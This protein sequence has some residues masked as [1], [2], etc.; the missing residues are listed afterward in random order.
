MALDCPRCRKAIEF[1]GER[2][3]Y[4]PYCGVTLSTEQRAPDRTTTYLPADPNRTEAALG[5][6]PDDDVPDC[7]GGFRLVRLLGA[8][9]M[10]SVFEG[11]NPESGQRVA[12]KLLNTPVAASAAAIER[13][14]QEGRLASQITHPNCVFVLRADEDAG[15]PFIVMELMSGVTLRDL[16]KQRGPLPPSEAVAKILD[17]IDGLIE[18]HRLNILHRDVKPSNCFLVKDGRVKVG[19]FGLSKSLHADVNLTQTG[20]FLGTVLYAPPEQL[21]GEALDLSAD[22]YAVAATLYFLLTGRAPFES[23]SPTTVIARVLS[24]SPPDVGL[25]RPELPRR[26]ARAVMRGLERSPDKRWSTL[27]EFRAALAEFAGVVLRPARISTRAAAFAIDLVLLMPAWIATTLFESWTGTEA[28]LMLAT[29]AAYFLVSEWQFGCTVG[30]WLL[31][32]RVVDGE[33]GDATSFAKAAGRTGIFFGITAGLGAAAEYAASRFGRAS[34]DD[35]IVI[36][37]LIDVAGSALLTA[38]ARSRSGPLQD[39]FSGTRVVQRP[40][41]RTPRPIRPFHTANPDL[42]PLVECPELPSEVGGFQIRGVLESANGRFRV[43]GSEPKLGRDAVVWFYPHGDAVVTDARRSLARPARA[44]WL[45]GG[46]V[47]ELTWDAFLAPV[48]PALDQVVRPG[49]GLGW[50]AT[51]LMLEQLADEILRSRE[52]APLAGS[53]S[54]ARVHVRPDGQVQISDRLPGAEHPGEARDLRFLASVARLALEGTAD[55]PSHLPVRAV[56]PLHAATVVNKLCASENGFTSVRSFREDLDVQHG[57]PAETTT[58]LRAVHLGAQAIAVAPVLVAVFL[59]SGL[60][61]GFHFLGLHARRNLLVEARQAVMARGHQHEG[62]PTRGD[63]D[64]AIARLDQERDRLRPGLN[65]AERLFFRLSEY[66]ILDR[67]EPDQRAEIDTLRPAVMRG[68]VDV[69]S[70]I[71]AMHVAVPAAFAVF[72]AAILAVWS[73]WA[74]AVRG[75]VSLSLAGLAL[76]RNDGRR[77]ARWQCALRPL[78]VWTP[79]MALLCA[80]VVVKCWG[81]RWIVA[82]NLLWWAAAVLTV[83][84][85]VTALLRPDRGPHDRLVGVQVV[86]R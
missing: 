69:E 49:E 48:A 61:N 32:L 77:A 44:R 28:P 8:G 70:Q 78:L 27:E 15:R 55:A 16:V 40:W 26:L 68:L 3:S 47:G 45:T 39:R 35:A 19:D 38:S 25:I 72:A 10:G 23:D 58:P 74:F 60:L 17:V 86:P 66:S 2:P 81:P 57:L 33:S 64:G 73:A 30:K 75:G 24:E 4:C 21:R 52:D 53:L 56:L 29:T 7:L 9:G 14:R 62:L 67:V 41:P 82:H 6:P 13:F 63:I 80:C 34:P 76:V 37:L 31:R 46:A 85:V 18:A 51:Q 11:V 22:V 20:S 71:D 36:A 79:V 50:P 65:A 42:R 59:I 43:L 12:V 1:S 54:T 84:A 5:R 83:G